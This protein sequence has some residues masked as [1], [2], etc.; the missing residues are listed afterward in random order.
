MNEQMA[1]LM[2]EIQTIEPQTRRLRLDQVADQISQR[3]GISV[4]KLLV[5]LYEDL[6]CGIPFRQTT[7]GKSCS[8]SM[9]L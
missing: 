6:Q 7:I 3:S 4:W 8:M 2:R 5:A 1:F 9:E